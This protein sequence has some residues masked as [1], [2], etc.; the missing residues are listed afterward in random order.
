MIVVIIQ[1]YKVML[2]VAMVD[3][4]S[5]YLPIGIAKKVCEVEKMMIDTA[6][7]KPFN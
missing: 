4:K 5:D 1:T 3:D 2:V 7:T 6:R